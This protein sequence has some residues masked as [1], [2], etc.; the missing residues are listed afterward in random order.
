MATIADIQAARVD[1]GGGYMRFE[2]IHAEVWTF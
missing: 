2:D 1:A